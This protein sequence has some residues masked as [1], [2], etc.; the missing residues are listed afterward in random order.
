MVLYIVLSHLI[1]FQLVA[2]F[3]PVLALFSVQLLVGDLQQRAVKIVM[4]GR[5]HFFK[6]PVPLSPAGSV[7]DDVGC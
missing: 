3:F 1:K 2:N 4:A 7:R 6:Q 5:R